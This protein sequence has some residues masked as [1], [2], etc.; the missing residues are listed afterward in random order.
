M[1]KYRGLL[2][3]LLLL[4]LVAGAAVASVALEDSAPTVAAIIRR[5]TVIVGAGLVITLWGEWRENRQRK[6]QRVE[7]QDDAA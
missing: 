7:A 1:Q 4:V 2:T 3:I 5:I 6:K